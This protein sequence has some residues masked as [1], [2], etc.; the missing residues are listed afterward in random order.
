MRRNI[1]SSVACP[2]VPYFY[3][4]SHKRHEFWENVIENKMCV[5]ILSTNFARNISHSKKIWARYYHKCTLVTMWSAVYSRQ[6]VMYLGFSPYILENVQIPNL[7]IIRQGRTELFHADGRT[8][9]T[10]LLVDFRKFANAPKNRIVLGRVYF[11]LV[12]NWTFILHRGNTVLLPPPLNRQA[13]SEQ[14]MSRDW[15]CL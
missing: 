3:T 2:I 8:D 14:N 13:L 7:M 6:I 9:F 12:T 4:L 15:Q 10:K 11:L 1:V 5:L